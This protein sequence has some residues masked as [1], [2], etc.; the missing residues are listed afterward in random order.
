[1]ITTSYVYNRKKTAKRG[2]P[3]LV[4]IRIT[5]RRKSWY[6]ST[7]IKVLKDEW[8]EGSVVTRNDAHMLNRRLAMMIEVVGKELDACILEQRPIDVDS[9]KCRLT[10]SVTNESERVT[11]WME[12]QLPALKL[13]PGTRKRYVTL[14]NRLSEYDGL[15]HWSDMTVEGIYNFDAWLHQRVKV[16]SGVC[17]GVKAGGVRGGAVLI[18]D[19]AVYNYHKCLKALLR[20][21]VR[22]GKILST[23]YDKLHGE[24][25]KGDKESTEFLTTDE[26]AAFESIHPVPGSE[27]AKA[28]DLFTWQMHTGMSYGDTQAFDF[29]KYRQ[30]N[31]RWTYIGPRVKTGVEYVVQL[32][33]VC[34]RIL[35]RYENTLPKLD[36]QRYN[37]CL[38]LIGACA[39]ISTPLHSHLARHSFATY[40]LE[41]DVPIQNVSK[42]LGHKRVTQTQRYAKV[43]AQ[44]V[45]DDFTRIAEQR[46]LHEIQKQ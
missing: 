37:Q 8:L 31:G 16:P 19:A 3:A 40:M 32:D 43:R 11:E 5:D 29:S 21:A 2:V 45:F 13:K 46:C 9:I 41:H 35:A 27:M 14:L 38:K 36:N 23:P 17:A 22:M 20:R 15:K 7:G 33:D 1:M 34:E 42:M 30:V 6:I 24:F 26:M 10:C 25:S 4:E 39:G 12:K 28:H 18:S 44:K